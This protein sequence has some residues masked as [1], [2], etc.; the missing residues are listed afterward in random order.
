M[1]LK[2]STKFDEARLRAELDR[3]LTPTQVDDILAKFRAE[4]GKVCGNDRNL[5]AWREAFHATSFG[6]A[7]GAT[8]LRIGDDPPDFLFKF[9]D[10]EF[11]VEITEIK[12]P[13][14]LLGKDFI[15]WAELE[16]QGLS[17]PATSYDPSEDWEGAPGRIR[18]AVAAKMSKPYPPE[19]I[20][21]LASVVFGLATTTFKP[22]KELKKL[23]PTEGPSSGKSGSQSGRSI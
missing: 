23:A 9:P 6:R 8:A 7:H 19:T 15:R 2:R 14:D 3:W 17:T 4:F 1:A 20:L 11:P 10:G 18:Q 16:E 22:F 12:S 5:K 13:Q 21:A